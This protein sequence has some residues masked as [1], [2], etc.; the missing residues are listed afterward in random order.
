MGGTQHYVYGGRGS[1]PWAARHGAFWHD[2]RAESR[3]ARGGRRQRWRNS[4]PKSHPKHLE[5]TYPVP[6]MVGARMQLHNGQERD[7]AALK[8]LNY[9]CAVA[10][11]RLLQRRLCN[12]YGLRHVGNLCGSRW[13]KGSSPALIGRICG[14]EILKNECGH[15]SPATMITLKNGSLDE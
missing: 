7:S 11:V 9:V 13:A 4:C 8:V 12:D 3:L 1:K 14:H 5:T 10:G 15:R 2:A 6:I